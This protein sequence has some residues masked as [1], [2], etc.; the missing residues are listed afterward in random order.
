MFPLWLSVRFLSA[1]V[2]RR[3]GLQQRR[4]PNTEPSNGAMTCGYPLF[5]RGLSTRPVA[6][7]APMCGRRGLGLI[8]QNAAREIFC[9]H[10]LQHSRPL[11]G[12]C[13][14]LTALKATRCA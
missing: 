7:G 8:D 1:N 6:S 12:R 10:E 3:W 2:E 5:N 11:L 13:R 9:W 4:R 14:L